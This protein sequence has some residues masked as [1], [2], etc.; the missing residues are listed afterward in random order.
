MN[1][2]VIDGVNGICVDSVRWGEAGSGIPAFDPDFE[3]L[4]EAIER[5]GDDGER[6]RLGAG[7]IGLRDGERSWRRT[8]EGLAGLLDAAAG[9]AAGR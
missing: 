9:D 7:A 3:Q 8:V 1:E 4:T 6:R 5:L 2:V